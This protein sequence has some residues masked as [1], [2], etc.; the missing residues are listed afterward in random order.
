MHGT[1]IP[2]FSPEGYGVRACYALRTLYL[3][4]AT[5]LTPCVTASLPD[6]L[7]RAS[8]AVSYTLDYTFL[9]NL[10]TRTPSLSRPELHI[11]VHVEVQRTT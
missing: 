4:R 6:S 7:C 9:R 5:L 10:H 3:L 2:V 11:H 8:N 1:H